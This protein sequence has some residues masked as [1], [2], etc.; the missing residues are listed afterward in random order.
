MGTK[1]KVGT[2]HA[3]RIVTMKSS[4]NSYRFSCSCT[5]NMMKCTAH[6]AAYFALECW[7]ISDL[8]I[9]TEDESTR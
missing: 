5:F 3:S 1:I 6:R 7:G 4:L 8:T 9:C 2:S